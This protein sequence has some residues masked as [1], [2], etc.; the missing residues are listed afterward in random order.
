MRDIKQRVDHVEVPQLDVASLVE[1][2]ERRLRRRRVTAVAGAAAVMLAVGIGVTTWNY[3]TT[4]SQEPVEQPSPDPTRTAERPLTYAVGSTIHHGAQTIDVEQEVHMVDVTDD[5][6][7][8]V[9]QSPDTTRY[10]QPG[11]KGLW[12]TDGSEVVQIGT[13]YGS[14][15]RGYGVTASDA[16]ST[17]VWT[18]PDGAW[19]DWSSDTR[20]VV[21][22]TESMQ[23]VT[24]LPD[25]LRAYDDAVYWMPAGTTCGEDGGPIGGEGTVSCSPNERVMR[26][27]VAAGSSEPVSWDAYQE[28]ASTR[29]RTIGARD[30][31][32]GTEP[33]S[34]IDLDFDRRGSELVISNRAGEATPVFTEARTGEPIRLRVPAGATT[35]T[36]FHASHW[37]DD[38]N[39]V[40]FGYTVMRTELADEGD[41]FACALSTGSCRRV[42]QGQPGTAYQLPRLD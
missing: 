4:S 32:G 11:A 12:F 15:A 16:G 5:G 27:D 31:D 24:R 17:L 23:V 28:D 9:R 33:R 19:S 13:V 7:V 2:G 20:S 8:F 38:D 10:E 18:E 36:L 14:P 39:L 1:S 40:L 22:D 29:P 25:V 34:L 35:A 41:I 3:Q 6:V 30:G 21:F 42:V 37:L 26:Y